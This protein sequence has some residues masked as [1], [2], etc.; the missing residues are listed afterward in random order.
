MCCIHL[1]MHEW[2]WN[3]IIMNQTELE[4]NQS[5]F[6]LN[7]FPSFL[8]QFVECDDKFITFLFLFL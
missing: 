2:I 6:H 4:P 7:M 5:S 1:I 8:L 3:K